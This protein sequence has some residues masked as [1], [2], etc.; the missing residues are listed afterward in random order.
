MHHLE[1]YVTLGCLRVLAIV[2]AQLLIE[3]LAQLHFL[4]KVCYAPLQILH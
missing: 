2:C 3:F 1:K 4:R